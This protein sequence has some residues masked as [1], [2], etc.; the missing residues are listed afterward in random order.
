MVKVTHWGH[1]FLVA[2]DVHSQFLDKKKTSLH[3]PSLCRCA[4]IHLCLLAFLKISTGGFTMLISTQGNR[5][6]HGA[7]LNEITR[8]Q[9][10]EHK[11]RRRRAKANSLLPEPQFLFIYATR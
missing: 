8:H 11:T 5:M 3:T 6:R 9:L 4:T 7:N 1:Q 10:D 2:N